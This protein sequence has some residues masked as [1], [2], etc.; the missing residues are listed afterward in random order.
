MTLRYLKL[1]EYKPGG[2]ELLA[3]HP[4]EHTTQAHQRQV[5]DELAQLHDI[6][7]GEGHIAVMEE[8]GEV[9]DKLELY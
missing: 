4:Y 9:V 5:A 2:A 7:A 1:Y 6:R 8:N 3:C